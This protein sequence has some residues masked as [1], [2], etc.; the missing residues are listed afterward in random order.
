MRHTLRALPLAMAM[1]AAGPAPVGLAQAQA[2]TCYSVPQLQAMVA[3]GEI[4]KLSNFLGEIRTVTGGGTP[5]DS[6]LCD[7]AGRRVYT[8]VVMVGGQPTLVRV[9]AVTGAVY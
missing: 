5:T 8:V 3:A 9:D 2:Q 6:K 4:Q 1:L 7:I